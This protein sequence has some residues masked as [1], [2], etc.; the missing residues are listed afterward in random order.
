MSDGCKRILNPFTGR[1]KGKARNKAREKY[2]LE[3]KIQN[4]AEKDKGQYLQ[5]R[6]L[7]RRILRR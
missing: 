1:K 3:E 2:M 5:S 6:R 7:F 4:L